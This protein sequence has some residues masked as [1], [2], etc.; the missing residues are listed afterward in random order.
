MSRSCQI[1]LSQSLANKVNCKVQTVCSHLYSKTS[2]EI[3]RL[4]SKNIFKI[5][6]DV[7]PT[8]TIPSSMKV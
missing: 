1:H 2:L 5:N 7:Q 3:W 8:K 6:K 4:K